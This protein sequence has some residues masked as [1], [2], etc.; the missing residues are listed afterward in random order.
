MLSNSN[1]QTIK[2]KYGG[3]IK[4]LI[5]FGDSCKEIDLNKGLLKDDTIKKFSPESNDFYKTW[6]LIVHDNYK[7]NN[8]IFFCVSC[9]TFGKRGKKDKHKNC[10]LIGRN[11]IYNFSRFLDIL[12]ANDLAT[13]ISSLQ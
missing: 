2:E 12:S 10:D 7:N 11:D 5:S 8:T 13:V 4:N 3:N 1:V 6:K 9:Y